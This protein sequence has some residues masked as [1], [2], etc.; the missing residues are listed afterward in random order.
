MSS[1]GAACTQSNIGWWFNLKMRIQ[2]IL[3]KSDLWR[4]RWCSIIWGWHFNFVWIFLCRKFSKKC[5]LT[6]Q[7]DALQVRSMIPLF[8]LLHHSW[9]SNLCTKESLEVQSFKAW[10]S[11]KPFNSV[12]LQLVCCFLFSVFL[13]FIFLHRILFLRWAG[14]SY[15]STSADG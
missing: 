9:Y 6:I 7:Q 11:M 3:S 12:I 1:S 2:K 10:V 14:Q 4:P 5:I 13:R 8:V 15:L